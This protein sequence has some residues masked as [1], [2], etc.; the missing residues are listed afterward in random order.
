MTDSVV[1]QRKPPR[2]EAATRAT[3]RRRAQ[4]LAL[5]LSARLAQLSDEWLTTFACALLDEIDRRGARRL[6]YDKWEEMNG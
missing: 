3:R 4:R 1:R 2:T 6:L 5:E